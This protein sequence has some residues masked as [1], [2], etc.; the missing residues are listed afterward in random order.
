MS[1]HQ[2]IKSTNPFDTDY[3]DIDDE[4]FLKNSRKPTS[5]Q[6]SF[7]AQVCIL[8]SPHLII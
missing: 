1:G 7:D 4:T 2:Y 8:F 6:N 3:D 5:N